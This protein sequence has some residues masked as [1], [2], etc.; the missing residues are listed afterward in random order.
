M[1]PASVRWV[2]D[3]S[4]V[5][6]ILD[7][8]LL[9]ARCEWLACRDVP[10]VVEAIRSLRVRGAP[11]IGIADSPLLRLVSVRPS[12]FAASFASSKKSS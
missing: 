7:Q 10:V 12:A 2:G 1:I 3:A 8:T 5:L 6:E 9:P 4:G 11:A